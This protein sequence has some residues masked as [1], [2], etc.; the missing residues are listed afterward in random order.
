MEDIREI[1]AP[2]NEKVF[3]ENRITEAAL[4]GVHYLYAVAADFCASRGIGYE[5]IEVTFAG[6]RREPAQG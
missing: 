4:V 2:Y 6:P 5:H 3:P 1:L